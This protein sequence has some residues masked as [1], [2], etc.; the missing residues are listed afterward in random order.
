MTSVFT[1]KI[2][3]ALALVCVLLLAMVVGLARQGG[4]PPHGEGPHDRQGPHSLLEHLSHELNLTDA[5]KEQIKQIESNFVATTKPLHDQMHK[6]EGSPFDSLKDG[7]F[8]EAAAR[9]AAQARAN[10][11]VE[12]EVAHARMLSQV[13]AILTP[14]QKAQVAA[15]RQQFE[16]MRQEHEAHRPSA[17]PDQD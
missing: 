10:I 12:L 17:N 14:E 1:N 4:P 7:A 5:Q 13:Y 8:D 15:K 9:A 6:A 11:Q 16:Q 2:K 3:G